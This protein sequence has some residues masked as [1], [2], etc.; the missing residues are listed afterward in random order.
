MHDTTRSGS[1]THRIRRRAP[2]ERLFGPPSSALV[3]LDLA[4]PEDIR[5]PT[6][7]LA[8]PLRSAAPGLLP[9]SAVLGAAA[10]LGQ[11]LPLHGFGLLLLGIVLQPVLHGALTGTANGIPVLREIRALLDLVFLLLTLATFAFMLAVPL[12]PV[13]LL[14]GNEIERTLPSPTTVWT[15]H[16]WLVA[17]AALAVFLRQ[18]PLLVASH[19]LDDLDAETRALLDASTGPLGRNLL[20]G[21]RGSNLILFWCLTGQPGSV[22]RAHLPVLAIAGPAVILATTSLTESMPA[23]L[24]F[25]LLLVPAAHLVMLERA[26][27]LRDAWIDRARAF[28]RADDEPPRTEPATPMEHASPNEAL[29]TAVD[30]R[31]VAAV[32]AAVEAGA[33]PDHRNPRGR[34]LLLDA[35]DRDANEVV[36]ALVALGADLALRDTDGRSLLHVACSRPRNEALIAWLVDQGCDPGARRTDGLTPLLEA[37]HLDLLENV[38]ALPWPVDDAAAQRRCVRAAVTPHGEQVLSWILD[39]TRDDRAAYRDDAETLHA[40]LARPAALR[41]LLRAGMPPDLSLEGR[42]ALQRAADDGRP[43]AL[44]ALLTAGADP[45]LKGR[46]GLTPLEAARVGADFEPHG[47]HADCVAIL[48]RALAARGA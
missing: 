37:I 31:D 33:D 3:D 23:S 36:R 7:D 39:R 20:L 18:W 26:L 46:S 8:G 25:A 48:E 40:A 15:L 12:F 45:T 17:A 44:Q 34:P 22:M 30:R 16:A 9:G 6:V 14:A 11:G 1:A 42:T 4:A 19:L 5:P 21:H 24:A 43:D 38:L 28:S 29:L 41:L 47:R 13:A 10:L 35:C 2:H 27:A 32:Q